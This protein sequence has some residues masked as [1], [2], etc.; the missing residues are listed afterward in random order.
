MFDSVEVSISASSG[1]RILS[2]NFWCFD[3]MCVVAKIVAYGRWQCN[4]VR[5]P[6]LRILI[7]NKSFSGKQAGM[8]LTKWI[9]CAYFAF[10]V[11]KPICA[12][13]NHQV[14]SR[15]LWNT[16][17]ELAS[18]TLKRNPTQ[19]YILS[20]WIQQFVLLST[21]YYYWCNEL[22]TDHDAPQVGVTCDWS[23]PI[24]AKN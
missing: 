17:L 2:E 9:C 5:C 4:D 1:G 15:L 13:S 23:A 20:T 3:V 10:G 11:L 12:S 6:H 24:R 8:W 18:L 19:I 7:Q 14:L 16:R 22:V 21:V